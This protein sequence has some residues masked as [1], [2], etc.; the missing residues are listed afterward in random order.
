MKNKM[1]DEYLLEKGYRKYS[2]TP[3]DNES[4][5]AR[6]QKR[7]DDDFGK[8][9][10]INILRWSQDYIPVSHRG[11]YWEPYAYEYEIHFSMHEDDKSLKLH[12]FNNWSLEDVEMFSEDFFE[13]MKPNYYEDWDGNRAVKL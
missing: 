12:F 9:Y 8:K 7:F 13:K 1:T 2:P 6:F 3:F 11:D 10:F 4:I 5:V